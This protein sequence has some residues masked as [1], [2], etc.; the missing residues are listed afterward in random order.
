M[1]LSPP[2]APAE[3]L[4][5]IRLEVFRSALSPPAD[6]MSLALQRAAYSTN[7]K[8]R[9]D[10]SC[11]MFDAQARIIAQSFTQTGPSRHAR[12]LRSA[13]GRHYGRDRLRPGDGLLCND[14][15]LG[16][17]HLNDVCLLAPIYDGSDRGRYTA[18]LAHHID[19]GGGTPGS[20]GLFQEIFQ[21]GLILPP[22]RV[23]VDG[24]VDENV[25]RLILRNVRAPRETGGDLRA[26]VAAVNIGGR[27]CER[28]SRAT[29]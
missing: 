1:A 17:I 11:A 19:V 13:H 26:Q 24:R 4:D 14:G 22:T 16:G 9:L 18:A 29:D 28:S 10:F 20:I 25:F 15:H 27:D 23:L 12:P 2:P 8:T 3:G 6:E 21:E 7:I 5:R